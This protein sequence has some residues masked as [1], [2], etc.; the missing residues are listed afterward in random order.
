MTII[1]DSEFIGQIRD[2]LHHAES[3][4]LADVYEALL[5]KK[6]VYLTDAVWIVDPIP[7]FSQKHFDFLINLISLSYSMGLDVLKA[8]EKGNVAYHACDDLPAEYLKQDYPR[9]N[10]RFSK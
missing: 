4:P 2:A 9:L 3:E 1:Y 7:Q 6:A 10:E 8:W 5:G